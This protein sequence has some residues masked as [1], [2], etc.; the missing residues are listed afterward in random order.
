MNRVGLQER[1]SRC[2]G[3]RSDATSA[4]KHVKHSLGPTLAGLLVPG[5]GPQPGVAE[6]TERPVASLRTKA[7]VIP[8]S[9]ESVRSLRRYP[10]P[11]T[12]AASEEW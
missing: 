1:P 7:K 10:T 8:T 5:G 12:V 9:H 11:P 3:L 2:I 4:G 6:K